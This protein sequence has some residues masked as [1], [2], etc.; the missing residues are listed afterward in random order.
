MAFLHARGARGLAVESV[1]QV[2]GGRGVQIAARTGRAWKQ[3]G[4]PVAARTIS[5]A[6]VIDAVGDPRPPRGPS[7]PRA[8]PGE[9]R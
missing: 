6:L 2:R 4:Q 3:P 5:D 8:C 9:P 1:C 7:D